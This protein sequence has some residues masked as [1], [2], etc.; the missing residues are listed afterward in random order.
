M[1]E[2]KPRRCATCCSVS[3]ASSRRRAVSVGN[4]VL[5]TALPVSAGASR[6]RN[7]SMPAFF[8]GS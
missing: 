1:Y 3:S 7:R 8:S 4:A 5:R 6:S 2:R